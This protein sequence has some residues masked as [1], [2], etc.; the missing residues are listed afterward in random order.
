MKKWWLIIIIIG[1]GLRLIGLDQWP[2]GETTEEALYKYR[3]TELRE[4]GKDETGRKWPIVFSSFKGYQGP[5]VS[6]LTMMGGARWP[7][8]I[9]AVA[10]LVAWG[11]LSKSLV[12]TA[13]V[14]L[15]PTMIMLSRSVSEWNA[16]LNVMLILGALIRWRVKKNNR[17]KYW[18]VLGLVVGGWLWLMRGQFNFGSD[19]SIINGI[20][21][22][23]EN[24]SRWFY[25]KSF[26]GTR[27]VENWLDN[28]KPQ[29]WFA[30]GD[31]NSVYGQTNFGVV[32]A[33]F[34]PA[35]LLGL[36]K[37]LK[38]KKW[39]L[40]GWMIVGV[41]PSVLSCPSP[42]QERVVV[43]V[44]AV[45]LICAYGWRRWMTML[46]IVN[47]LFVTFDMVKNEP[48]RI[49]AK[50]LTGTVGVAKEISDRVNNYDW[51]YVSDGYQPDI[52][53]VLAA[54]LNWKT[55]LWGEK[56][57]AKQWI[58]QIGKITIGQKDSWQ[59]TEGK[60]LMVTSTVDELE[61]LER[62]APTK[63]GGSDGCWQLVTEPENYKLWHRTTVECQ[64]RK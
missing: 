14:A 41:L 1:A 54:D 30:A 53:T 26:Y 52:G 24:G 57:Q 32:L 64:N 12:A 19:I 51:I 43:A 63:T 49:Q 58:N 10:A 22:F 56:L 34:V 21:R 3:G 17:N 46:V 50:R 60:I 59:L 38:E 8:A 44:L 47:L 29:Y 15:S 37:T 62:L 25:N 2:M 35:F 39:W 27:L 23:R 40:V 13:V 4:E 16:M 55:N 33:A 45:A 20:N 31:K 18:I 42:N 7:M 11:Y 28:L 9:L 48:R 61:L 36:Q 6:Y 5:V